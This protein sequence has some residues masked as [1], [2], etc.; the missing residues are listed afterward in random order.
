[1]T[2][3]SYFLHYN[4]LLRTGFYSSVMI[5]IIISTFGFNFLKEGRIVKEVQCKQPPLCILPTTNA[6]RGLGMARTSI[7]EITDLQGQEYS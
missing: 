7:P 1:M 5:W 2:I 6:K 4:S 3:L